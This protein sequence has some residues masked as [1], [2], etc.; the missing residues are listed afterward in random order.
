MIRQ[1]NPGVNIFIFDTKNFGLQGAVHVLFVYKNT[2]TMLKN[3]GTEQKVDIRKLRRLCHL[4][5]HTAHVYHADS[6]Q[7]ISLSFLNNKIIKSIKTKFEPN[8]LKFSK[9]SFQTSPRA[10]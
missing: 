3:G 5:C 10:R 9:F 6:D 8:S 2:P 7:P 4:A 1:K